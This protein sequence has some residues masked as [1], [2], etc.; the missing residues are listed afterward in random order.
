MNT[1]L[2]VE[3]PV[4]EFVTGLDLVKLQIKVAQGDPLPF[5][6]EDLAQ[7]GHAIE[8]RV[9]AEDP[10]NDFLPAVGKILRA[11]EPRGPGIRV[12][13]GVQTGDEI[14]IY[15]DPMIAKLIVYAETRADAIQR[16]DAAL[17]SYIVIGPTTNLRFLRDLINHPEFAAGPPTTPVIPRYLCDWHTLPHPSAP[18]S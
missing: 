12:D 18:Q 4:T 7:R 10:A 2:Q 5:R 3:H 15:Y 11:I 6:Q 13:S 1:R 9:Y 16:M 8:C 17:A 14:T